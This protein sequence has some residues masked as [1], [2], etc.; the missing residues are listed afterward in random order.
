MIGTRTRLRKAGLTGQSS[1]TENSKKGGGEKYN[2]I[3]LARCKGLFDKW[4]S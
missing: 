4:G 3:L 1:K 2:P